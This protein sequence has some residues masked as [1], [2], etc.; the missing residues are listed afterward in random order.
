MTARHGLVA[1]TKGPAKHASGPLA[2]AG[3][4]ARPSAHGID[5]REGSRLDGSAKRVRARRPNQDSDEGGLSIWIRPD[6]SVRAGGWRLDWPESRIRGQ[7]AA[8]IAGAQEQFPDLGYE[9]A[10]LAGLDDAC[11]RTG[12]HRA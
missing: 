3:S 7:A 1:A 5:P 6:R 9:C 2:A 11:V 12:I 4:P 10:R 8:G